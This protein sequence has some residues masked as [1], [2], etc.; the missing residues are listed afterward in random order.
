MH[1]MAVGLAEAILSHRMQD[2][3]LH[4]EHPIQLLASKDLITL[5]E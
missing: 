5:I 1:D 3:S 4:T 2:L